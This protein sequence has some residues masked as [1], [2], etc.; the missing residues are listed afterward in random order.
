[1]SGATVMT[2][3]VNVSIDRSPLE[4]VLRVWR[5]MSDDRIPRYPILTAL[6]KR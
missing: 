2:R 5:H 4:D 3:C 6:M 1:M